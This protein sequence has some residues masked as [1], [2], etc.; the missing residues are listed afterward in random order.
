MSSKPQSHSGFALSNDDVLRLLEDRSPE[1]LVEVTGKIAG[2]YSRAPMNPRESEAAEQIFRLL[3]RDT[4]ISVRAGLSEH[5][6]ASKHLPRDIV[7]TLARDVE[8]VALPV[9]QHSEAL[10]ES[11]LIE[12]VNATE[13]PARHLA[14]ARRDHVPAGVSSTL[15]TRGN[16]EVAETLV[17]NA[18][19]DMTE[20]TMSR[21]VERFP[22]N[23]PMMSALVSRPLLPA[24]VAEKLIAHVS[25]SL[26]KTLKDKHHLAD[27]D[28]EQEVE[29]TREGETL[30]L[31][32]N[33]RDAAEIDRLVAQLIG[34]HRLTP[35]IILS[36][37]C[38][39]NFLFFE[40]ALARLSHIAVSNAHALITDK[41]DLGFR[42][43]YNKS[44]LP[45]AMFPAVR[46][47]LQSVRQLESEG[48]RPGQSSRYANRL[49]ERILHAAETS[50]VENLSY[51]LALVRRTA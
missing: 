19:A 43:L 49:A 13:T 3:L 23:K 2:A 41:G 28:I 11:D 27:H 24:T 34:F 16:E 1:T 15:V 31:L 4:E 26:A 20:D 38:Q 36:A 47:L 14:I 21:I 6:K 40:T 7:M 17:D 32:R 35:S 46:T 42:A 48:E 18:G 44:G 5:V 29:R 30:K 10:T 25:D 50:P 51:I 9:L 12:L 45:E 39:G 8:Q 22:E 37:L 33:M